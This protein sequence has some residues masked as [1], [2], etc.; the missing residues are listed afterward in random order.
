MDSIVV[1]VDFNIFESSLAKS[2]CICLLMSH[3]ASA[4]YRSRLACLVFVSYS[5]GG[6]MRP[7]CAGQLG[8]HRARGRPIRCQPYQFGWVVGCGGVSI[9]LLR[10]G[11]FGSSY[12]SRVWLKFATQV[13]QVFE[14]AC[15]HR[16]SAL[17]ACCLRDWGRDSGEK[18][19][20]KKK[21]SLFE[22]IGL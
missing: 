16:D 11:P 12:T 1:S 14:C 17:L 5:F 7:A 21:N 2:A 6:L 15:R 9:S 22:N 20:K 19:E 8:P 13:A 10:C 3:A 18:N 4:M